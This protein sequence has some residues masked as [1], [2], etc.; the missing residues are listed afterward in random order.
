MVLDKAKNTE[1][2]DA[3]QLRIL[4]VDDDELNRR[5]MKILLTREGHH[6]DLAADGMEALDAVKYQEFDIVFMDL[7]MPTMDGVEASQR[8]R[9]WENGG[10]HT[11]IVALTASY[12]PEEGHILFSAGIDNYISKPFEVDHIQ[13]MLSLI[14]RKVPATVTQLEPVSIGE[15]DIA[16]LDVPKGIQRV[17]GDPANYRELLSDFVRGMPGR[18][19]TFERHFRDRNVDAISR[20]SHNLKG[21]AANLGALELADCADKLDKQGNEGYTH[22]HEG[23]F[24]ELKR[25]KDNLIKTANGFLVKKESTIVEA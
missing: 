23:L 19:E 18:M 8:I 6:V 17:G 5:M 3:Q 10:R 14:S 22:A 12:M 11:F 7:Q 9:D 24:L 13:R 16:V 1:N 15:V 25:A 20:E 2:A 4:V 21:V